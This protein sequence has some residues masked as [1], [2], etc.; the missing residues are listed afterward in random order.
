MHSELFNLW[1][2]A[3][4]IAK[5]SLTTGFAPWLLAATI[6]AKRLDAKRKAKLIMFPGARRRTQNFLR[7]AVR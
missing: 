2:F 6:A 1:L 3:Q 5:L 4:A 7:R